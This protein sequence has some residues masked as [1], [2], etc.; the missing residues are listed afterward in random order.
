MTVQ[1]IEAL[2][3]NGKMNISQSERP[4]QGGFALFQSSASNL[5]QVLDL[6]FCSELDSSC[7]ALQ[8]SNRIHGMPDAKSFFFKGVVLVY[9]A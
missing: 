2:H 3:S 4:G 9:N 5:F 1:L 7:K 8:G 6:S